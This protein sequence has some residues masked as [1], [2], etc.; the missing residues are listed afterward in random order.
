MPRFA[1][2]LPALLLTV[3]IASTGLAGKR[4]G[5]GKFEAS[6][7]GG[8][9]INSPETQDGGASVVVVRSNRGGTAARILWKNTFYGNTG[10]RSIIRTIW[11]LRPDGTFVAR[12]I[13]PT[14]SGVAATGTYTLAN[15]RITF[16]ASSGDTSATGT[17][18]LVGGG[19]LSISLT[20]DTAT[21]EFHGGRR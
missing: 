2:F 12:T 9:N 1:P 4:D 21:I 18:S 19:A 17:V 3:A 11:L 7:D 13:D 14:R 10:R 16:A 8:Y 5:L 20:V 6:Y 15:R